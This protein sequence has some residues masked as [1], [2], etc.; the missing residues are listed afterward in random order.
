MAGNVWG[1]SLGEGY[2]S[3]KHLS[4]KLRMA[5]Q[6]MVKFRQFSDVRD[7]SQQGLHKGDTY[8]YNV[9]QNVNTAGNT[10]GITSHTTATVGAVSGISSTTNLMPETDFETVQG[11][12]TIKE[13][14]KLIAALFSNLVNDF[15]SVVVSFNMTSMA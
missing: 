1:G 6:P 9:Y 4:K 11:S 7:A 13:F 14:G 2:L 5:L 15:R 3:S 8:T 12:I 10:A